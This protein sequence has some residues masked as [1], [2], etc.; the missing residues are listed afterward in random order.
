MATIFR[1]PTFQ[2][3]Y[4]YVVTV[5]QNEE[6]LWKREFRNK[7]NTIPASNILLSSS[8]PATLFTGDSQRLTAFCLPYRS[9]GQVCLAY[10]LIMYYHENPFL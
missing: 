8:M 2:S 3:V 1:A 9:K 4:G 5:D 7:L 10:I 6:H